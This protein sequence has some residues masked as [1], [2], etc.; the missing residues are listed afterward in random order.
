MFLNS[1]SYCGIAISAKG[2]ALQV[3]KRTEVGNID[4]EP[5]VTQGLTGVNY[6]D[7]V[8]VGRRSK[9]VSGR[10]RGSESISVGK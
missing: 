2:G 3:A 10:L 6:D 8:G 9:C 5:Y 1:K 7:G 4:A